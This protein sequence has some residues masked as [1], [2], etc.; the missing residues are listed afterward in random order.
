VTFNAIA[1]RHGQLDRCLIVVAEVDC[2]MTDI[3][4]F[5]GFGGKLI[6]LIVRSLLQL[7]RQCP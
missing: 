3:N 5:A 1:Q 2:H 7:P 6:S 4:L